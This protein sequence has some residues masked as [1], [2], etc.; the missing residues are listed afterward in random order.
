MRRD[1]CIGEMR[2][3]SEIW[4]MNTDEIMRESCYNQI[5]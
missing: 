4:N 3:D 1:G 5:A 2:S